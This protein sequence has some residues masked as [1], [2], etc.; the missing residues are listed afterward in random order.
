VPSKL[1]TNESIWDFREEQTKMNPTSE[2][3]AWLELEQS[4]MQYQCRWLPSQPGTNESMKGEQRKRSPVRE[5]RTWLGPEHNPGGKSMC[6][7]NGTKGLG[8]NSS[9]GSVH[10]PARVPKDGGYDRTNGAG[11]V[12]TVS[13]NPLLPA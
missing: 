9:G 8:S 6:C 2:A 5:Q 11:A 4:Q 3:R 12:L 1:G 7:C 10:A 13:Q